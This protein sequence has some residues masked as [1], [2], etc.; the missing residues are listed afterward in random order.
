MLAVLS[1]MFGAYGLIMTAWFSWVGF[2]HTWGV[3][4]TDIGACVAVCVARNVATSSPA[5]ARVLFAWLVLG[6]GGEGSGSDCR[7]AV[8]I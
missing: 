5:G 8:D 2:N 3:I 7:R 4:F 6:E 1:G